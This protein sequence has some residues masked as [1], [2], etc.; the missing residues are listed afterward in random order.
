MGNALKTSSQI[1]IDNLSETIT[2]ISM[3]TVQD[4]LVN[5]DQNQSVNINNS[6]FKL[7]GSY[8]VEQ[9]TD[10]NSKCFSDVNKEAQ[11]QT[12]IVNAISNA[13]TAEG[14]ALLP[15]FGGTQAEAITTLKNIVKT[16]I[17]MDSIQKNY[18]AIKQNQSVSMNNSG[19]VI[20][21]Q[22]NIS[23]G[24]KVFAA[25]TLQQVSNS[26]IFNR[27][28]SHI[29]QTTSATSKNPLSFIGDSAKIIIFLIFFVIIVIVLF[30]F[31]IPYKLFS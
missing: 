31:G 23:Q 9:Q 25:A 30:V 15:A 24:A 13:A 22:V 7:W 16:S 8:N 3:Q 6:G 11:L 19:T 26:G 27:I 29:D 4:C 21:E 18:N 28:S 12:A 10:V 20:V 1:A 5:V 17:N 2:S 14:V